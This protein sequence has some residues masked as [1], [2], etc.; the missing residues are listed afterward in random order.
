MFTDGIT[1]TIV[2]EITGSAIQ[3]LDEVE[4]RY[5]T[6]EIK[7]LHIWDDSPQ[8]NQ[9]GS[10]PWFGVFGGAGVGRGRT[11]GGAGVSIGSGF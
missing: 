3:R 5:P 4:Y 1:V 6:V 10:R 7:H 8:D 2:A 11:G 9:Y